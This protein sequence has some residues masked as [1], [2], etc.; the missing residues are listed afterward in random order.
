VKLF[1]AGEGTAMSDKSDSWAA[2]GG[3]Q[4]AF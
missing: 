4:V 3:A 2:T 1:V